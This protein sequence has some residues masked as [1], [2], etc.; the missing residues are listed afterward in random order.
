MEPIV[1]FALP[2]TTLLLLG[3]DLRTAAPLALLGVLPDLDSLLL[4][5]RSFSHS[6]VILGLLF[7]P[8]LLVARR[9]RPAHQRTVILAFLVVASHL[10]L[11]LG[12]LTPILWPLIPYDFSVKFSLNV[13][14]GNGLGLSPSLQV[15]QAPTDFSRLPGIDY[16]LFTEE[17]L[18]LTVVLLIPI[19]YNLANRAPKGARGGEAVPSGNQRI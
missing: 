19:L 8:I 13:V 10:F 15:T 1:H 5:H 4:I 16:P 2:L 12:G 3:L 11:D 18:F 17:G 7:L 9:Y 6:I 14:L